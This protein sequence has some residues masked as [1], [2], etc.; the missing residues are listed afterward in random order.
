MAVNLLVN[1]DDWTSLIAL[2]C[3]PFIDHFYKLE[4]SLTV[5]LSICVC[6]RP[7]RYREHLC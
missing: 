4:H 6:F 2:S 3:V 1:D 5:Y 7:A